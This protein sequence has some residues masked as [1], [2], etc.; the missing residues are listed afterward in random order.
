MPP[1]RDLVPNVYPQLLKALHYNS[2]NRLSYLYQSSYSTLYCCSRSRRRDDVFRTKVELLL[3]NA[4]I[5]KKI[6]K[7]PTETRGKVLFRRR[8][9][10]GSAVHALVHSSED[11]A[12]SPNHKLSGWTK[13]IFFFSF[14]FGKFRNHVIA[15]LPTQYHYT[16]SWCSINIFFHLL[17]IGCK[18]RTYEFRSINEF[19]IRS[20]T[21]W[22]SV[23]STRSYTYRIVIH[24][25]LK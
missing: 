2:I 12:K 7:K 22:F 6:K 13:H 17:D 11:I 14:L 9:G 16:T 24:N 10:R 1:L 20:K 8:Y 25:I 5:L 18:E 21:F 4:R 19:R 3:H 23:I 15:N